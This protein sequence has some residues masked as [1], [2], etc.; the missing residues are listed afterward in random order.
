MSENEVT[1]VLFTR[2]QGLATVVWNPRTDRALC[3]FSKQGLLAT[4]NKQVIETLREMGYREV[5]A[6]QIIQAGLTV[7]GV[8]DVHD[9]GTPGLGYREA[10]NAPAGTGTAMAGAGPDAQTAEQ[11]KG[12]F[13]PDENGLPEPPPGGSRKLVD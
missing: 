6:D 8:K 1:T 3:H 12:L 7:P 5:T 4:R 9:A 2:V 10:G 11:R 13:A